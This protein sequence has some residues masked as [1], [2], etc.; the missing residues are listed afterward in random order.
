MLLREMLQLVKYVMLL[1]MPKCLGFG[2]GIFGEFLWL[3]VI[4]KGPDVW[5][6]VLVHDVW[7]FVLVHSPYF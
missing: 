1:P 4:C 3:S 7:V 2:V 5:V 6:F